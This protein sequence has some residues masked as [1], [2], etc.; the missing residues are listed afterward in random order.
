MA[1]FQ[2]ERTSNILILPK[3]K[4]KMRSWDLGK[5]QVGR[6]RTGTWCQAAPN[7]W[8]HHGQHPQL[9]DPE[10]TRNDTVAEGRNTRA[11]HLKSLGAGDGSSEDTL[12]TVSRT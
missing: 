10:S 11:N 2:L 7:L 12:D 3:W 1:I 9:R 6:E 5:L 8:V 4:T